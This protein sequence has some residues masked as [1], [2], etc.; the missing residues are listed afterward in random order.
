MAF[1]KKGAAA[2]H[3][4]LTKVKGLE[5]ILEKF[6]DF[7][8]EIKKLPGNPTVQQI[9]ALIPNDSK[10]QQSFDVA[11]ALIIKGAGLLGSFASEL[12]N[13]LKDKT[14][15]ERNANL[16]KLASVATAVADEHKHSE[17]FYDT[18]TQV[19]IEGLK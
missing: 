7:T 16:F 5:P 18:A 11:L 4:F 14:E 2:L 17:S 12:S 3:D 1:C 8:G 19:H 15:M 6:V 13:W 10:L 9:D